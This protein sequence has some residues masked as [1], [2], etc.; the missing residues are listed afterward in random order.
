MEESWKLCQVSEVGREGSQCPTLR[1][2]AGQSSFG[3]A[4]GFLLSDEL[5]W[6]SYCLM[7]SLV[8]VSRAGADVQSTV[9][10]V[11]PGSY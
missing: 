9:G 10:E 11:S 2:V 5:V 6:G 7:P 4:V 1:G 8:E 3:G